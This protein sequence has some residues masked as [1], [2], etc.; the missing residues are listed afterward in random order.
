M[1]SLFLS[2]T[3]VAATLA[4]FVFVARTARATE[5]KGHPVDMPSY[6]DAAGLDVTYKTVKLRKIAYGS[7]GLGHVRDLEKPFTFGP[8]NAVL[9]WRLPW[10]WNESRLDRLSRH[11]LRGGP[12]VSFLLPLATWTS[13]E[14]QFGSFQYLFAK[15]D[16]DPRLGSFCRGIGRGRHSFEAVLVLNIE[17]D[18]LL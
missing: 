15:V 8:L 1:F 10:R 2:R 14:T 4:T 9:K 17:M 13:L 6:A 11:G 18:R 7:L 3:A 12:L 5:Q 16:Q